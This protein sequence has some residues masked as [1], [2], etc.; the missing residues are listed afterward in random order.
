[1]FKTNGEDQ[2]LL[3][4]L[5]QDEGETLNVVDWTMIHGIF[6]RKPTIQVLASTDRLQTDPK[7]P[8]KATAVPTRVVHVPGENRM[9]GCYIVEYANLQECNDNIWRKR[10]RYN[11]TDPTHDLIEPRVWDHVDRTP[12]EASH[13]YGRGA[14]TGRRGPPQAS[15]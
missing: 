14:I 13:E 6:P 4:S 5:F 1:M 3:R 7:S 2:R 8:K 15:W 9:K 11:Y 12:E 10:V